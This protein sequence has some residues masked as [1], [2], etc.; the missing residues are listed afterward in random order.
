MKRGGK[1][2]ERGKGRK[3]KREEIGRQID[4]L[5]IEGEEARYLVKKS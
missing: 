2:E 5:E 4:R 1:G 3:E